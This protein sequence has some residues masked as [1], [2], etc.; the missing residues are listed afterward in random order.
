MS[1]NQS[2]RSSFSHVQR[3]A[4]VVLL[5]CALAVIA[6]F[7]ISWVIMPMV[8]HAADNIVE[9]DPSQYPLD[10]TSEALLKQ[11]SEIDGYMSGTV[12]VGGRNTVALQRMGLLTLDEFV[13]SEDLSL[14]TLLR[15]ECVYFVDDVSGYTVPQAIVKMKPRRLVVMLGENEISAGMDVDLFLTDFHQALQA[16]ASAYSY[17]DMIVCAVPPVAESEK[18][19]D[20]MQ[21]R[22]DS[23]N[24]SLLE[25]CEGNDYHF[26]N[27]AETLKNATGF[28][29]SNYLDSSGTLNAAGGNA[30]LMYYRQHPLY[31]EDRRPDTNDI[32]LRATDPASAV[33]TVNPSP[34]P[35]RLTA[36]YRIADATQGTLQTTYNGG[37]SG[38][39]QLDLEVPE[40]QNVTVEA[41]AAEGW[42]FVRWS[43]GQTSNPRTDIVTKSFSV[44]AEFED[45]RLDVTLDGKDTQIEVGE[46]ITL[47]ASVTYAGEPYTNERVAQWV[48]NED[49]PVEN[50]NFDFVE[51]G[52]QFTFTP[53]VAGT[54]VIVFAA[55]VNGS[56]DKEQITVTVPQ[57]KTFAIK[58][59]A[60]SAQVNEFVTLNAEREG[61][62][63]TVEWHC[64]QIAA[65]TWSPTG[66]TVTF[67]AEE[68]GT[69]EVYAECG[70]YRSNKIVITV[71]DNTPTPT[72]TSQSFP[73]G[74]GRAGS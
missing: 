23:I 36:T 2:G 6:S 25:L 27:I 26:L 30:L 14:S 42:R 11:G 64:D 12:F 7:I 62:E 34:T 51:D 19:S 39:V 44:T 66:D 70:D 15:E 53:K 58:A 49:Y 63:G 41:V 46:S 54:Y 17:C 13:G 20:E 38:V 67:S 60:E 48:V 47:H 1:R 8:L 65:D 56:R 9:Y 52:F 3:H 31:S 29:E 32:P 10:N 59:S 50:E 37:L 4:C 74:L 45:A 16:I 57:P 22:I 21:L 73:F 61:L 35:N 33:A 72:P 68:A 24:Q 18:N 43:D 5:C 71:E 69:Y 55:E 40:Q 28:A